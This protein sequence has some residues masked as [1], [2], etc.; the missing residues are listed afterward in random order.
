VTL[1]SVI[2]PFKKNNE[3]LKKSLDSFNAIDNCKLFN[4]ILIPDEEFIL[5]KNYRYK[6]SIIPSGKISPAKKRDLGCQY[7][8]TKYIFFIDD[9]A[10]PSKDIFDKALKIFEKNCNISSLVGPAITPKE[11]NNF[12]KLSNIFFSSRFGGG[13]PDRY[14][15]SNNTYEVNDWPTVNFFIKKES[16]EL[17]NGFDTDIWPGEDTIFCEKLINNNMKILFD[18]SLVVYHYRRTNW[19]KH[20]N[21]ISNYGYQR[22]FLFRK[23]LKNSFNLKFLF[24]SLFMISVM[25]SLVNIY[26]QSFSLIVFNLLNL[27]YLFLIIFLSIYNKKNLLKL[28]LIFF[29]SHNVYGYKFIKGFFSKNSKFLNQL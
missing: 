16:Y 12:G 26:F 8:Q 18:G 25:M 10:Y 24:P 6:I 4:I 22:G 2:I 21:Q 15:E 23:Q 3:Y 29:I 19:S 5:K 28:F 20:I 9:D 27:I 14:N 7:I 11:E 13:F 17:I 1:F